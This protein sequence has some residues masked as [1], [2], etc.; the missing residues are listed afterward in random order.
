MGRG[1]RLPACEIQYEKEGR[2]RGMSIMHNVIEGK[3]VYIGDVWE[4][5]CLYE[6]CIHV[7]TNINV[8]IYT[9]V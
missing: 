7:C 9:Q 4:V 8:H 6:D 2:G 3:D 1:N 5:M